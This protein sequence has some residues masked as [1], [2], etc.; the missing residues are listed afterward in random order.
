MRRH[1]SR[2]L[3]TALLGGALATMTVV[4]I[5]AVPAAPPPLTGSVSCTLTAASTFNPPLAY[6]RGLLGKKVGPNV[7][8]KW[9]LEGTL[10]GCTGTQTGGSPRT[11]GPIDHGEI[12]VKAKATGHH[13]ALLTEHGMTV[14]KVRIKWFDAAGNTKST[15]K[16][17]GTATVTGLGNG[18]KYLAFDP[19]V[20]DPN[21]VPPGIITVHVSAT[22]KPSSGAFPNQALTMT[23]VADQTIDSLPFICHTVPFSPPL[24]S[25]FYG[26][27]FNG[28]NAPSTTSIS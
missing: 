2:L 5:P 23:A 10:T 17:T 18:S 15:T 26:L 3:I 24:T 21:Y 8:S 20:I 28:V 16:G 13:C 14:K 11:P 22:G 9:L 1:R 4:D 7:N 25:G 6:Q 27:D 19:P 12:L